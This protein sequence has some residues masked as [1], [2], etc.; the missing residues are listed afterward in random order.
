MASKPM[1]LNGS[2]DPTGQRPCQ[3]P[4]VT[5]AK[6]ELYAPGTWER[7]EMG[8]GRVM[9]A[10]RSGPDWVHGRAQGAGHCPTLPRLWAST[11]QRP[12]F[13]QWSQRAFTNENQ[14]TCGPYLNTLTGSPSPS[15]RAPNLYCCLAGLWHGPQQP[16]H[17]GMCTG[18]KAAVLSWTGSFE[19]CH[20]C[21]SLPGT[22]SSPNYHPHTLS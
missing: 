9:D 6:Q 3:L 5:A 1:L 16:C 12:H 18:H 15:E 7:L 22:F 13:T 21:Y 2:P 20:T 11:Q 19:D 17:P 10:H 4:R 8:K 14:M